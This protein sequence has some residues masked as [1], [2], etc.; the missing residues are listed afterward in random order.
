MGPESLVPIGV[1]EEPAVEHEVYVGRHP[2]L[3]SERENGGSHGAALVFPAEYLHQPR[4]E[5][6]D[7]QLAGIH[8][9]IGPITNITQELPLL[10][11]RLLDTARLLRVATPGALEAADE[12]IV[13]GIQKEDPNPVSPGFQ[14]IDGG[15]YI[16]E[17]SPSASNHEGHP[18]HLRSTAIYQFRDLGDCLLYT[19]PSPRDRQKSRMP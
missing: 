17:V 18:L 16:V 10:G 13:G 19:S 15:Q 9:Q 12:H 5:L 4:P 8:D 11:D 3:E 2:V 14:R 1:G 6:V 7:V